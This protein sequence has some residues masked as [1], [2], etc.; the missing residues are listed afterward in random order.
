LIEKVFGGRRALGLW[1]AACLFAAGQSV[2][3]VAVHAGACQKSTFKVALDIGHYKAAPGAISARG[4]TEFTYNHALAELVLAALKAQGFETAFL[5]GESGEPLPLSRRPQIAQEANADLFISLHHDSAQQQYFSE[6]TF[7]GHP[8][9]YSDNFHG[10]SIFVSTSSRRASDSM[11]LATMLGRALEANGLT[12]SLHH[13]EP[14]PGEGRTLLNPAL[15][16]Y[17]FDQLA[18]LRGATMPALLLESALI[19]NRDEEQAIQAGTYHPRV[20]AALVK[21]ITEYCSRH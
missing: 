1:L 2:A 7:E 20:V 6:W 5:I 14:I 17:R 9:P 10:Y 3:Q 18:V 19:V 8:H 21:A 15:G 4:I 13:A 11:E 16:I 12:P